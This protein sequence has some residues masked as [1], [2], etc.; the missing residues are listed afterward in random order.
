MYVDRTNCM[1]VSTDLLFISVYLFSSSLH[2]PPP[3]FFPFYSV[4][5]LLEIW[6][7]KDTDTRLFVFFFSES[8]KCSVRS[9]TQWSMDRRSMHVDEFHRDL[10]SWNNP[11]HYNKVHTCKDKEAA[12][13]WVKLHGCHVLTACFPHALRGWGVRGRALPPLLPHVQLTFLQAWLR[14]LTIHWT[15]VWH[16]KYHYPVS[17]PRAVL[18]TT[19]QYGLFQLTGAYIFLQSW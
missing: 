14:V 8:P 12:L 4:K 5:V 16:T 9:E 6:F 17:W 10:F 15:L 7:Y 13:A 19:R 18:K 3:L 2:P 11:K 1:S